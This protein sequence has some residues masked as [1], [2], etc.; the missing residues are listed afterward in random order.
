VNAGVTESEDHSAWDPNVLPPP[1]AKGAKDELFLLTIDSMRARR[2]P[3]AIL[4]LWAWQTALAIVVAW[5]T[6]AAVGS[7]YGKHPSGDAPLW[8]PGGLPLVDLLFD[9]RGARMETITL[10]GIV[11]LIAGFADLVPLGALVTS[12]AFVTRDRR[13]PPMQEALARAAVAFPTLASLFAMASMVEGLLAAIALFVVFVASD[14]M[15]ARLGDARADQTAALIALA[16]LALAGV[17][18]V[19]HDLARAAAIRFRVRALRSWQMA[20]DTFVHAPG[21]TLWSWAWR[22]LA[23]WAPVGV[24]AAVAAR[25]GG[26]DGKALVALFVVHQLVLIVRVAFRASWLASAVRAVDRAQRARQKRE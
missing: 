13:A 5:P 22:A 18:G 10:A 8:T 19:V 1:G 16:V 7:W 14:S 2:R 21:S 26:R 6:A 9:A 17:A 20:L 15:A 11:F 23:G 3:V 12:I 25:V 4:V 24:G